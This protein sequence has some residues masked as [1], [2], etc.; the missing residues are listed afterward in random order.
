MASLI[1]GIVGLTVVPLI[2]SVVALVL[3]YQS[4]NAARAEPARY[5][6]QLGQIGRI[7]GWIGVALP[8]GALLIAVL[9]FFFVAS[10]GIMG[11]SV[12]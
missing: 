9:V 7:L 3:G 1:F 11:F 6:D 2:G 4:R 10:I 8:L 12:T 5:T